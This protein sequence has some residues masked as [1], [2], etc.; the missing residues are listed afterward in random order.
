MNPS[1]NPYKD[2]N[3]VYH[4]SITCVEKKFDNDVKITLVAFCVASFNLSSCES[5]S[6][7]FIL[8]YW[9]MLD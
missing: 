5:D 6:F 7:I 8:W 2:T 1:Q 9:V 3:M 4:L